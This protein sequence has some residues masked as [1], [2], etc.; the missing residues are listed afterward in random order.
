[1]AEQAVAG[2]LRQAPH[3]SRTFWMMVCTVMFVM[4]GSRSR[5]LK[6]MASKPSSAAPTGPAARANRASG[7]VRGQWRR[8]SAPCTL[9]R[10]PGATIA[11]PLAAF[12]RRARTVCGSDGAKLVFMVDSPI[13][14]AKLRLA[15]TELL[16]AARSVGL[17]RSGRDQDHDTAAVAGATGTAR[18]LADVG[19]DARGVAGGFGI[20]RCP[21]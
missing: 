20:A 3:C 19:R 5:A 9:A 17:E 14:R 16:A 4:S 11:S 8:S 18:S 10:S 12:T 7:A 15:S 21:R 1:M 13:W 2:A 6:G